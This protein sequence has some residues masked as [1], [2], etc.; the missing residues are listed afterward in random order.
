M[1]GSL[2]SIDILIISGQVAEQWKHET[3][4]SLKSIYLFNIHWLIFQGFSKTVHLSYS[5]YI[6]ALVVNWS[7]IEIIKTDTDYL[8][9]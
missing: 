1:I 7:R 2:I 3:I 5:Y 8:T 4:C 6:V 9:S